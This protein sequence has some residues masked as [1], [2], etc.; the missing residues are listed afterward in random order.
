MWHLQKYDGKTDE[1]IIEKDIEDKEVTLGAIQ[2]EYEYITF[3]YPN[4]T[5]TVIRVWKKTVWYPLS[6]PLFVFILEFKENKA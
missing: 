4:R 6:K 2:R 1:L 3:E 5:K